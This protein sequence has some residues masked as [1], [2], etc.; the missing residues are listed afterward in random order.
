MRID[1]SD[2]RRK[3]DDRRAAPLVTHPEA[4]FF[5]ESRQDLIDI[6]RRSLEAPQLPEVRACG[7]H[8]SLSDA[9]VSRRFIVE[10]RGFAETDGF[11]ETPF[12]NNTLYDVIPGCLS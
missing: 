5:P 8:W 1:N 2:W 12:L 7:S 9:A 6:V 11:P 4:H 3:H 10:T